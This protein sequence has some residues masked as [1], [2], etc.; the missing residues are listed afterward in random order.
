MKDQAKA[1]RCGPAF[2]LPPSAF[3]LPGRWFD[4][5]LIAAGE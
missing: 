3:P 2:P 1:A 5:G 4:A